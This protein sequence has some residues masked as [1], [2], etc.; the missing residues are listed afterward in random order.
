[1]ILENRIMVLRTMKAIILSKL[2]NSHL[3][4]VK[5]KSRANFLFYWPNMDIE[6]EELIT[7][8]KVCEKYSFRNCKQ[9]MKIEEHL[10]L[11]FQKI[12]CYILAYKSH[13]QLILGDFYSKW[14]EI[15]KLKAKSSENIITVLQIIF[16]IHGIYNELR[17]NNMLLTLLK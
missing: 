13:S 2:H 9:Q 6:I 8:C 14:I 3:E 10:K 17:L 15:I 5:A 16:S 12:G 1:M 4:M 11:T 7:K